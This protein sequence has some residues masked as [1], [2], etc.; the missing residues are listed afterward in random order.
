M[1]ALEDRTEEEE[2]GERGFKFAIAGLIALFLLHGLLGC[3]AAPILATIAISQ[4][5][6]YGSRRA[7]AGLI[8]A[9]LTIAVFLVSWIPYLT[10]AATF[11]HTTTTLW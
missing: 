10:G 4:C 8:I 1:V 5:A 7:K 9:C 2:F 11:T 3:W 6:G